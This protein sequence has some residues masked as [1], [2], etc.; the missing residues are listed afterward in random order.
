MECYP[1]IKKNKI[2][3][4]AGNWM[5]PEIIMLNKQTKKTNIEC[6]LS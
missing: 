6:F 1:A 2:R 4:F 3:S 5:E